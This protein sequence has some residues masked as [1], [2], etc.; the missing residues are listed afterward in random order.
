MF[1]T[2]HVVE[3]LRYES[4]LIKETDEWMNDT[5]AVDNLRW[6]RYIDIH[7]IVSRDQVLIMSLNTSWERNFLSSNSLRLFDFV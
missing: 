1:Y 2:L 6:W 7:G 4:V 5:T 3:P